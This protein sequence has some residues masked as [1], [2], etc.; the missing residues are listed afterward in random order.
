MP[1]RTPA[2]MH[3]PMR[4]RLRQSA[5]LSLL[6]LFGACSSGSN[7]NPSSPSPTPSP[8]PSPAPA[9]SPN[10]A[11]VINSMSANPGFGIATLTAFALTA[12]ATDPDGDPVTFEWELGDG[13]RGTGAALSKT[14]LTDGAA[15]I[16]VTASDGRGGTATDRRTITVGSMTGSWSGTVNVGGNDN[17]PSTMSLAQVGGVITGTLTLAGFNGRTDPA[18]LG[19][20][21]T[22]G[23][24]EIRW[25]VDPFLD[26][27]MRGQMDPTGRRVSGGTFGSGF[28]G[29]PFSYDKR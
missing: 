22:N 18:Q 1:E 6:L 17:Q 9:P 7:G 21:D 12:A 25:K 13:T 19:R 24:F 3:S 2:A 4:P 28:A 10:R 15:T 20:I 11:P 29:E 8:T 16:T 26:F 23:A 14:Y 27:T 5:L